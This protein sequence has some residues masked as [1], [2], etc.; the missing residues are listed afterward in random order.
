MRKAIRWVLREYIK[1][2]LSK[3][4]EFQ[5]TPNLKLL[6]RKEALKIYGIIKIIVI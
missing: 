3:V 2:K 1:T 4:K 5:A 6:G